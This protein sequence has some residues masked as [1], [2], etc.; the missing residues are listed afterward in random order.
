[1]NNINSIEDQITLEYHGQPVE[2]GRMNSYDVA[3]YIIAFSDF[4]GVISRKS[5]GE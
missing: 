4:L 2:L 3:G 5:Y 1:M